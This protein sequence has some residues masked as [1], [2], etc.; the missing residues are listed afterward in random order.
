MDTDTNSTELTFDDIVNSCANVIGQKEAD[1][2]I[3]EWHGG[4]SE[5]ALDWFIGLLIDK[6]IELSPAAHDQIATFARE[7]DE[8]NQQMWERYNQE[9]TP[10]QIQK[11]NLKPGRTDYLETFE[12]AFP[13]KS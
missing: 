1:E 2:L 4:E 3:Y 8:H 12:E 7:H 13:K 9:M 10:E 6:K 5:I 11:H